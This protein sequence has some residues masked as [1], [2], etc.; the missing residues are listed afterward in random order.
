MRAAVAQHIRGL[1]TLVEQEGNGLFRCHFIPTRMKQNILTEAGC[2]FASSPRHASVSLLNSARRLLVF[3]AFNSLCATRA[4][5]ALRSVR[6]WER[7]LF[8]LETRLCSPG[9][10][11]I[12]LI[13]FPF[14]AR[15]VVA[16]L[17]GGSS[18]P[19]SFGDRGL[20][21]TGPNRFSTSHQPEHAP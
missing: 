8:V 7:M 17:H 11:P 20:H 14:S 5:L 10:Q 18:F 4:R 9:P 21:G 1:R 12:S 19:K 3:S 6:V 15:R 13:P 2:H 16:F